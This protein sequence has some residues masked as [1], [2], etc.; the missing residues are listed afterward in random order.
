MTQGLRWLTLQVMTVGLASVLLSCLLLGTLAVATKGIRAQR[1][2]RRE[3][4]LAPY[5]PALLQLAAGDDDPAARSLLQGVPG[6]S[7]PAVR[8]AV[9]GFLAKVKG[10]TARELVQVLDDHRSIEAARRDTTSRNSVRRGRAAVLLGRSGRRDALPV[11]LPLLRDADPLVRQSAATAVGN[12]GDPSAATAVLTAARSHKGIGGIPSGV[13]VDALLGMDYG[14]EDSL[15]DALRDPDPGV[16]TVAATVVAERT[17]VDVRRTVRELLLTERHP[18]VQAALCRALGRIGDESDVPALATAARSGATQRRRAAVAALGEIDG[19]SAVPVLAELL[20]DDDRRIAA[21]AALAL[22]AM[23]RPE[24][25]A[26]LA[27]P[28]DDRSR[29]AASYVRA[30]QALRAGGSR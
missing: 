12:L 20:R 9:V 7:W 29:A 5:R 18:E 1:R 15:A 10:E 4:H 14:I 23:H 3:R 8:D 13:A 24:A 25:A 6:R 11:L 2:R 21:A 22:F 30:L 27:D 16:R 17:T 19:V 28:G 26:A